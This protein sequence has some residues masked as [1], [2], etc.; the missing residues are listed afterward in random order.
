MGKQEVTI[1]KEG[2]VL[3]RTGDAVV[4]F[5]CPDCGEQI[6][7]TQFNLIEITCRCGYD[8]KMQF[9]VVGTKKIKKNMEYTKGGEL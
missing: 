7:I 5:R 4:I 6:L 1:K 3:K 2:F 8:W 9:N